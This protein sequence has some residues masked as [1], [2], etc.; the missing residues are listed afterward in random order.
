MD[1]EI[2]KKVTEIVCQAWKELDASLFEPI[3]SEDFEYISVWVLETMKGKDR[4]M[5]YITGKFESITLNPVYNLAI[6]V[7]Y[8]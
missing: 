5:D 8:L 2:G 6:M 7:K 4:Y 3:L 1:K